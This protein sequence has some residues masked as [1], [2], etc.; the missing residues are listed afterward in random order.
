[1]SHTCTEDILVQQTTAKYLVHQHGWESVYACNH[2]NF[3]PDSQLGRSSNREVVLIRPLRAKL[4]ELNPGLPVNQYA[5]ND[6]QA[7]ADEVFRHVFHAYPTI[8][9]PY[10]QARA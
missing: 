8:P 2:E 7:C 1:M 5:E 3:V 9:S 6:V 10:Y 4:I